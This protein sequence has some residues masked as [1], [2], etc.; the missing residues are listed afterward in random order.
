[1]ELGEIKD[2]VTIAKPFVEPIISTLISP[3]I[4]QLKEWLKNQNTN[5]KVI[6]NFYENKFEE[7][8][9]R[10]YSNCSNLNVLVFPNQ[11]ILIKDIYQ[12]I[13]LKSTKNNESYKVECFEEDLFKSYK[14]ILISDNAG[15]GKS[16]LLK[17]IS[18][19]L[20]ENSVSIP[21]L[22]ELKKI[23]KNHTLIDE[24]F[25]QL[26]PI[27]KEFDKGL[28]LRF[29]ELGSFTILF[30]GFDEIE[31]SKRAIVIKD[32][33]SLT[34]KASENWFVLTSRPDSELTAFGEFQRFKINPLSKEES[35]ELIDKYD[36]LFNN[37]LSQKLKEEIEVK[38]SQ[39][40]E[41]LTN[42][43]LVSLL[44]NT[45]IY[46]KNIPSKKS[47]FYDDVY[48]ALYKH[49]DLSKDGFERIKKS[50]LDR[51]DFRLVLRRLAFD[52]AKISKTEYTESQLIKLLK[53]VVKVLSIDFKELSYSEDLEF[54]VP[55]F[56]R[57]GKSLKWSHKSLQDYFAA[58]YICNHPQKKE[59]LN[60]IYDSKKY[61][62][63]QIIDFVAELEPQ[64]FNEIIV[65]PLLDRFIGQCDST[66]KSFKFSKKEISK[67][68]SLTFGILFG[69]KNRVGATRDWFQEFEDDKMNILRDFSS[70]SI[71]YSVY[72]ESPSMEIII[73][74][75]DQQIIN[76]IGNR[77][78]NL[79]VK[80]T[81]IKNDAPLEIKLPSNDIILL[82]DK[83]DC[84]FNQ[85]SVF[86]LVSDK[87][88][89][90][91]AD[92]FVFEYDKAVQGV[93]SIKK[94][95]KTELASDILKG[96]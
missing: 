80:N 76:I 53:E 51:H 79:V 21:V 7:Y 61:N 13:T 17:R 16:T 25:E 74:S 70:N 96:I 42:P 66:Y 85:V 64:L 44:Y 15:M 3:K 75:Y 62:Y 77:G 48:L 72:N 23:N 50:G 24:I 36:S 52:T 9:Y 84:I 86:T 71:S 58:E 27:D 78:D 87:I 43:F 11:Q 82:N 12:P 90:L 1:M 14:R 94:Q 91:T 33:K 4:E 6:D 92:S 29:L 89:S 38:F 39:V 60:K 46:H 10:T 49:H 19:L 93:H 57:D 69:M 2:I 63:L 68:Q 41:F 5:N 88:S 59:I 56:I 83:S 26:N 81:A 31:N 73:K 40:K 28:I 67:R 20:I 30:D 8:L 37:H 55:L 47:T 34:S 54:N 45:Y 95:L 35:F 22:I 65:L 32:I 18:I